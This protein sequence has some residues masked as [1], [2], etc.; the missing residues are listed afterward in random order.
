M[1][2]FNLINNAIHHGM[3]NNDSTALIITIDEN[4]ITF[5]NEQESAVREQQ[6]FSLGLKTY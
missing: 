5:S 4:K 1:I 2:F 6:H 3:Q